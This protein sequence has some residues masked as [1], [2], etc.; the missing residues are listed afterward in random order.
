MYI[1]TASTIILYTVH[2]KFGVRKVGEWANLN[3]LEGK[4]LVNELQLV[5]KGSNW[6]VNIGEFF[7]MYS[8]SFLIFCEIL[9]TR[10]FLH[11]Q[12]VYT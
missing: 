3:Q 5:V 7:P 11:I 8:I 6:R 10:T 12:Y 9:Y 2:G 4:I 1:H